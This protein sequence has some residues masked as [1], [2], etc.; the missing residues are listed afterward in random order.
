M[1]KASE[2]IFLSFGREGIKK[3]K[4]GPDKRDLLVEHYYKWEVSKRE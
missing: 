3:K 4:Q 1:N 2:M